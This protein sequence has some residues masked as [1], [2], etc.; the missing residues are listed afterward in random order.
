MMHNG[1]KLVINKVVWPLHPFTTAH[2]AAQ[3]FCRG[4]LE[5]NW[6]LYMELLRIKCKRN[7]QTYCRR[8]LMLSMSKVVCQKRRNSGLVRGV[9]STQAFNWSAFENKN[10]LLHV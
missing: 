8:V 1:E 6:V 2:R 9:F 7:N 3:T 4:E 5:M 10:E